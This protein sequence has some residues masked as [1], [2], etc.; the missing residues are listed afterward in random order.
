[1]AVRDT[2]NKIEELVASASHLPLTGKAL[3]NEDDLLQLIEEFRNELPQE[4]GRAEEVLREHDE[5]L[6]A[7]Q[8]EADK[9]IKQAEKQAQKLVDE[10]D[11]VIKAREKAHILEIQAQREYATTLANNRTQAQQFQN[12]VIQYANQVFD[13]LIANVT[14]TANCVNELEM[15]LK[16]A[17]QVLQQSKS[18]LGQ[19]AYANY[20]QQNY[21][22]QN[23]QQQNYQQQNYQQQNYQQQNYPQQNY[24]QPQQNYQQQNYQQPQQ[25]YQQPQ[26]NY[27]QPQQNYQQPQQNYQQPQQDYQ[28]PQ[29]DY[30]QPQQDYPQDP[31]S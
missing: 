12:G 25:N 18:A 23:Y 8:Q 10:N 2:L 27:Q 4:L 22:Q 28:Q 30:Q 26:Q 17:M 14:N 13:Q 15:T 7:A 11:V 6:R 21:Q 1:M 31:K 5:I 24:Q 3:I 20:Q 19:Q 9:I 29:Q 16:Q